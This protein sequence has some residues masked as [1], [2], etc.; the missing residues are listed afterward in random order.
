[1]LSEFSEDNK[2]KKR[3]FFNLTLILWNSFF[4]FFIKSYH[5]LYQITLSVRIKIIKRTNIWLSMNFICLPCRGMTFNN[6]S[7]NRTFDLFPLLRPLR[8]MKTLEKLVHLRSNLGY[9]LEKSRLVK[10]HYFVCIHRRSM[11]VCLFRDKI[12]NIQKA[13]LEIA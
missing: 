2:A 8:S 7:Y 9:P 12:C 13:A 6:F 1:M 5:F 3:C 10:L 11:R 4:F